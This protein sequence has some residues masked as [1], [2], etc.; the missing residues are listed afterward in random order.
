[1]TPLEELA[2]L[3]K[4]AGGGLYLVS[5]GKAEQQALQ[6]R[7]YGADSD[8]DITQR[9]LADLARIAQ[10]KVVLLGIPSDVGAGFRRGAN[11]G[12]QAIRTRLLDDDPAFPE[13][14]AKHGVLDIGDVFVVP[15]LL[16]DEMLSANQ[17]ARCQSALYPELAPG[18]R[19]AM[20]VSPLSIAERALGLVLAINPSVLPLM[21]GGDHSTAWPM[22]K[23]LHQ[24]GR[25]FAILHI[26]AHTDLLRERLGIE[27]CF[28]TWSYHANELIGRSGRLIQVGIRATRFPREHWEHQLDVRQFW[29]EEQ[30]DD[31]QLLQRALQA[32]ERTGLPVYLSNDIDGTDASDADATGTPESGGLRAT[33]VREL[34]SRLSRHTR[35]VGADLVEVAPLLGRDAGT[36]TLEVAADY[37]R[38]TLD[39][40]LH[41]I[42]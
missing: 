9:F 33:L 41:S 12:P 18:A 32:V 29:P 31:E 20:P 30:Q 38:V 19:A 22:V 37:V 28:A 15:Q 11:L 40:L 7:F 24:A 13:Y 34:I 8:A 14:C 2:L 25:R 16:H 1:M 27:H 42:E 23:A 6:R 10:A 36:R 21:L 17:I 35:L 3:L 5:T 39:G 26:D 4:P